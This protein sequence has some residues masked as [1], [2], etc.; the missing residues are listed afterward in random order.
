MKLKDAIL[1]SLE[2][3]D[4]PSTPTEVLNHIIEKGYY[5]FENALTP[6]DTVQ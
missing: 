4:K 2:M 1:K 3:M 6:S 5:D